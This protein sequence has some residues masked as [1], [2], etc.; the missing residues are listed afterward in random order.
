MSRLFVRLI[1]RGSSGPRFNFPIIS[2][3]R[4]III[5]TKASCTSLDHFYFIYVCLVAGNMSRRSTTMTSDPS[6]TYL[7]I[8][9]LLRN[10]TGVL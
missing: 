5:V 7:C 4:F 9:R 8:C 3:I 2:D 10:A 1:F 6:H